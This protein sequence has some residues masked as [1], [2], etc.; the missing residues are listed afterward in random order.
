MGQ[1][2]RARD[3]KLNRDVALKILPEAFALDGDRIARFR[4]EAQVL[5]ALNHPHI[6]QIYGLEEATATQFLVLE[7]V[8]GESLD[9]RL[10]RGRIPV[11]EALGIAK[12]MAEALEAAHDKGII[13]RDLKPA[14][15]SLTSDG[16]AKVLDFGLAKT[17]EMANATSIGVASS[18]TITSPA[19]TR[20][21]VIL[22]TAAYMA[23]EQAKG[24]AADKRSDIWAFG[25]VLFEMLTGERAFG[26]DDVSETLAMILQGQPDWNALPPSTPPNLRRLL[27][28]CLDR[29]PRRRL[30]AIGEA[31]VKVENL[32][33][34][35]PEDVGPRHLAIWQRP[36]FWT[37]TC[38][39]C[40]AASAAATSVWMSQRKAAPHSPV[41]LEA[42]LGV[43]APLSTETGPGAVL[44]PDGSVVA[45]VVQGVNG[46]QLHVR[47]LD[48][49]RATPLAGTTDAIS[50]FFSPDGQWIGF[51]ANGKLKKVSVT[52][53][54]SVTLCDAP[55][56]R[57][58]WW[59]DDGTIVFQPIGTAG[60]LQH[61]SA[62]GGSPQPLTTLDE[63]EVTQRWPQVLPGGSILYT[64]AKLLGNYADASIVVQPAS[65]ARPTVL[66]RG[67]YFG[68]YV[69]S[70]HLVF[71][72]DGAL[73]AA[74]F[75]LDHLALTGSP[76]PVIEAINSTASIGSGQF[77]VSDTGTAVYFAGPGVASPVVWLTRD[78]KTAPLRSIAADW[79]NPRFSPDGQRLALDIYDGKQT[80]IFVYEWTRDALTRLTFEQGEQWHP[81]WT[82]DG[83]RIVYRWS[84]PGG[85]LNL[86]WRRS[87]G[88]GN[89]QRLTNGRNPQIPGSWHPSGRFLIYVETTP[90]TS[91]DL[92]LLPV[93]GDETSGWKFGKPE[94]FVNTPADETAPA[95]SP[96]GR[97]V[98]YQSNES[99]RAEVY[100]RPF[101]GP[102]GYWQVSTGGGRAPVW[103][104]TQHELLYVGVDNRIMSALYS[105]KN[106]SFVAE[107]PRPWSDVRLLTR[108]R[109]PAGTGGMP[110]DLHP[111]GRRVAIALLGDNQA[112]LPANTVVFIFNFFDE[113][114]RIAPVR[115]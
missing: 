33:E 107:T 53:G 42:R 45:L 89:V 35:V 14:N 32:L 19:M 4:R 85:T 54:A 111:D 56:E 16:Q 81:L 30:Q 24:H 64:S 26:G 88:G 46:R 7:L 71:V 10:A 6:A 102:G 22:G 94:P 38:V 99:G 67:G 52:G 114:R 1:V 106:D 36:L 83:R 92:M 76:V 18:P 113:L 13:H 39:A 62:E 72:R 101:P 43:D 98:A 61:V 21:G 58:A 66:V 74:P 68:R 96:D 27:N 34:G 8:D 93:D 60:A 17:I 80:S 75:D 9:K 11:D 79:S 77:A 86:Y 28:R 41:R 112:A 63:G 48:Q 50:P 47:R 104:S 31:R 87:D 49:L 37:V 44:S 73:F 100:V 5:A 91:L 12:Q 15:V 110:F 103:S 82:P 109:G 95:F 90:A 97:W 78:G 51:F 70:G 105:V 69:R 2:Y 40:A 65:K 25:C 59:G 84:E 23:P 57:G 29:D 20:V 55:N 3:T 115:H 108:P